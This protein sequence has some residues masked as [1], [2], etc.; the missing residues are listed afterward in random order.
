MLSLVPVALEVLEDP[1]APPAL[2]SVACKTLLAALTA[3]IEVPPAA[4]MV[5]WRWLLV[6]DQGASALHPHEL[7]SA[8]VA[9][10]A[11]RILTTDPDAG[12][13]ARDL[14]MA[15]LRGANLAV[16]TASDL[17]LLADGVVNE[18]RTRRF[19]YLV[20]SLHELKGLAPDFLRMLRD[21][22][23]LSSLPSV[24]AAGVEVGALLDRLDDYF[25]ERMLMDDS[26]I[27]RRTVLEVLE[28]VE[29]LDRENAAVIVRKHLGSAER[30]RTVI[31]A[32]LSALGA[33]VKRK[34]EAN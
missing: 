12:E 21:R 5:I 29:V 2:R 24:R 30:H 10:D 7:P 20:E 31:A 32:G 15:I 22:L 34:P 6:S 23:A 16:V 28:R 13:E 27:V 4:P 1:D 11:L 14:A 8:D 3:G 26:P 33:L 25:T 17:L 9:R 19:T 18:G